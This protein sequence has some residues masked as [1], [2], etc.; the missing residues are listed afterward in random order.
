MRPLRLLGRGLCSGFPHYGWATHQPDPHSHPSSMET[1][2]IS[3]PLLQEVV[4]GPPCDGWGDGWMKP[5]LHPWCGLAQG[6]VGGSPRGGLWLAVPPSHVSALA[7]AGPR[8]HGS[9]EALECSA[10]RGL[11][12]LRGCAEQWQRS[13][14]APSAPRLCPGTR[15]GSPLPVSPGPQPLWCCH[16]TQEQSLRG[17]AAAAL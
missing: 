10:Q 14:L 2:V 3:L 8:V 17:S 7:H 4:S 11:S 6:G 16:H 12:L 15:L 13:A 9:W 5:D 1:P